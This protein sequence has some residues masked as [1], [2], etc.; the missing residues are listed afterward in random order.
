MG[1]T[2]RRGPKGDVPGRVAG[3][4]CKY[5]TVKVRHGGGADLLAWTRGRRM[6]LRAMFVQALREFMAS[7]PEGLERIKSPE[8]AEQ[9]TVLVPVAVWQDLEN[10]LQDRRPLNKQTVLALAVEKF[11]ATHT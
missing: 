2:K 7:P 6:T 10:F 4:D 1:E 8:D 3:A 9:V 5:L 11:Q